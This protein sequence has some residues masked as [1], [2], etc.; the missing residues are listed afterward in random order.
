MDKKRFVQVYDITIIAISIQVID[1]LQVCSWQSMLHKR[2][3]VY[4]MMWW[5]FEI[6]SPSLN[7]HSDLYSSS[8]E[9]HPLLHSAE[10]IRI[11]T[12]IYRTK[13]YVE[14]KV[15]RNLFR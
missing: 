13:S 14:T 11:V 10:E 3:E 1:K 15:L 12:E 5:R 2:W 8:I 9:R 6:T 7:W 4:H